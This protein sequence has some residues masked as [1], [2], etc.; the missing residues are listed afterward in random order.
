M[1]ASRNTTL[2]SGGY[3]GVRMSTEQLIERV[4]SLSA[5]EQSSVIQF[6]DYLERRHAQASTPFLQ[7]AEEFIAQ[8]PELLR[9]LSQ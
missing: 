1:L 3:T 5:E 9:R 8:H 7:A 2:S 6:I 4:K